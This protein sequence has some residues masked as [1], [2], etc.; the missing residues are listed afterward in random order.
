MR[1]T[2]RLRG[3]GRVEVAAYGLAD[4]EHVVA[5]ELARLWPDAHVLV[6]DIRRLDDRPRI[7]ESFAV[8]YRITATVEVDAASRD[9][10]PAAA[11]R[12]ARGLL[13]GSRYERTVWEKAVMVE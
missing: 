6:P 3:T 10:A 7:V 1:F 11:Y 9:E 2:V 12:H 5:K 4:A 8:A 13:S